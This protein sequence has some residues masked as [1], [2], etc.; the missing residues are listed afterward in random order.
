M[1]GVRSGRGWWWLV[2]GCG[3][4]PWASAQ[5]AGRLA[6]EDDYF[7]HVPV[8]LTASRLDQPLN[9][10]PGAITVLDRHTIRQSGARTVADVLRLVP[11]YLSGGWNGA[12]PVAAYH[13]PLD[14]QGTRN[15]V[16]IDGRSVYSSGYLG[17]THRGMMDV[18]LEDIERIEVLRGANSAAYGANAMFGVINIITRH[19]ADTL[20]G[21][22]QVTSGNSGV[23]DRRVRVGAG[24]DAASFRLA[25]GEKR[26]NGYLNVYDDMRLGHL[27]GR[28][29]FRPT[30]MD[31]LMITAGV[32]YLSAGEGFPGSNSNP[33]HKIHTRDSYVNGRWRHQVSDTDEIQL[34]ANFSEDRRAESTPYPLDP[35]VMLDF[36]VLGRRINVELQS[37]TAWSAAVR[38]VLGVGYKDER[39][40]SRPLFAQDDWVVMREPRVFGTAEWRVA[41][42]WLVN[43]GLFVGKQSMTGSYAAP[44]LM[45][46][47]MPSPEHTFRAG[48][49][50]SVR[51]PTLFEHAGDI[52]YYINGTL[53]GQ[54]VAAR[55][56]V[57]PEKLRSEELGYHGR[58]PDKQVTVDV[59]LYH[60]HMDTVIGRYW[61]RRPSRLPATGWNV[62]DYA[63][64]P[65]L[66]LAGLEYQVRWK[67]FESSELW[68]NQSF[69][70]MRW[71]D[72]NLARRDERMPPEHATTI[73][74]FQRF[75]DDWRGSVLHQRMGSMTWRDDRDWLPVMH[76]TDLRL[77]RLFR[78]GAAKGEAALTV[79]SAEGSQ[80]VFLIREN[81]RMERRTFLTVKLEI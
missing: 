33:L 59:R 57:R 5:E 47:W 19:S 44:R 49:T 24:N 81:F 18:M 63:N 64:R 38:T 35:R 27:D 46:N 72:P 76:R 34:T 77:A 62:M 71:D 54:T 21:E 36:G 20:G 80:P 70:Q 58:F 23:S 79:Q 31:D 29:D 53:V 8:V 26:D 74:W 4:L 42:E 78:I 68:F 39:A 2:W 11:G 32:S 67:P 14:D 75:G 41:P 73:A 50:E 25:A 22:V 56:E 55:G 6:S 17:D 16:L 66:D 65:G 40:L 30:L 60:E 43:A 3:V 13:V 10:A 9:E 28:A 1:A 51:P 61:Y 15:L 37:K 69:T 48:F 7:A 45:V 52:R 12:N